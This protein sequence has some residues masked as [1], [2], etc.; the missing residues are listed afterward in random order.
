MCSSYVLC[1]L[2]LYKSHCFLFP[3]YPSVLITKALDLQ[4]AH[5]LILRCFV[6][7]WLALSI[8]FPLQMMLAPGAVAILRY[9]IFGHI[10]WASPIHC[11]V[12]TSNYLPKSYK[13]NNID[14]P[15]FH[16]GIALPFVEG[17]GK[18]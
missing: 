12:L 16:V 10:L 1:S 4:V 5:G 3:F 7:R 8:D 15:A 14:Q 2:S 9:V 11:I 17:S 6:K 13:N 18:V